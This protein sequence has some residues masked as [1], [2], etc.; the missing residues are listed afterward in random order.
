MK[1]NLRIYLKKTENNKKTQKHKISKK[2][3]TK[4]EMYTSVLAH[5]N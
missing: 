5:K 4:L 2:F 1:K 3:R